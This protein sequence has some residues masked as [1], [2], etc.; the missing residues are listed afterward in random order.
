[1]SQLPSIPFSEVKTVT[2]WSN[3]HGTVR[4]V[5]LPV[6]C[7]PDVMQEAGTSG[8]RRLA[9]HGSAL[10]AL[11]KHCFDHQLTLRTLGGRWSMSNVLAPADV[12]LDP[13]NLN[14]VL[15]VRK[16]WQTDE[17]HQRQTNSHGTPVFVQGGTHIASLNRRLAQSGL[18]L[19]TSGASDGHRIAGCIAT[20]THGSALS[21]GAVHDTVLAVHLMVSPDRCLLL[22]PRSAYFT[23]D[24]AHWLQTETGLPTDAIADDDLFHAALVS[25]GSLGIVHG[26]VLEAVPLYR[27]LQRQ[28]LRTL[29]HPDVQGA[30][31]TLATRPFHTPIAER[32][33]HFQ[34][35]LHPYPEPGS[36]AAFCTMYWK[37]PSTVSHP[38]S[39]APVEPDLSSDVMGLIASLS[40]TVD[41]PGSTE[42]IRHF[43]DD[44][45]AHRYK[46]G[47]GHTGFPG[48]IFG[49]TS[50]PPGHGTSTEIVVALEDATVAVDTIY[51]V[52]Q[53]EASHGKH[54]LGAIGLRFVPKTRAL[55][56]MNIHAMNC[57]IELP[58]IANDEVESIYRKVWAALQSG[59]TGYALHWGQR[60]QFSRAQLDT[61]YG[62]RTLR[63]AKARHAI[64][65]SPKARQVFAT[66]LLAE[67]G[68]D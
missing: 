40:N 33:Y 3:Y 47:H 10:R 59:G 28:E 19:Q 31:S 12:T 11:V 36:P 56:G 34:L 37:V 62:D 65:S 26:V 35:V 32:P 20:G 5:S 51:E 13:A 9:R 1:M 6:Y 39:P 16:E 38:T 15:K 8:P 41:L 63:W 68:L 57:Y 61:Y 22:Q 42:L 66:P 43:L 24:L 50:L 25:L 7:T 45:L 46:P 52:L 55:L 44:Q 17:Y 30:L 14:V 53:R 48:E 2:R 64:L 54:L 4:D 18:A 49:P 21:V 27:L 23:D 58:S 29:R 60:L 67:V